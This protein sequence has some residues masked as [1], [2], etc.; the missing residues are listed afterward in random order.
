MMGRDP[1]EYTKECISRKSC[2]VSLLCSGFDVIEYCQD[3]CFHSIGSRKLTYLKQLGFITQVP[4]VRIR[5][6][7]EGEP[8]DEY[9]PNGNILY[10]NTVNKRFH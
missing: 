5:M 4:L 10:L 7:G 1:L 3:S 6:L 2:E 8:I 9:L